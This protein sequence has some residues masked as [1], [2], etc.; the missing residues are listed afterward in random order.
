MSAG[1]IVLIGAN[2]MLGK[3]LARRLG[4]GG[5]AFR[6][7]TRDE[8]DLGRPESIR[9]LVA[10]ADPETVINAAAFTDVVR[11]ELAEI[12]PEVFGVNRDGPGELA[13]ACA[14]R[15]VRLVHVSTDYVFDGLK[16]APYT[17]HD[18]TAP[19]QVYGRSKLEGELAV[20]QAC[21]EALVVRTS[22]LYGPGRSVR[23]TYVDA[24]RAQAQARALI[25]VVEPPIASPTLSLDLAAGILSLVDAGASGVVHVVNRGSCSRLE[26]ARAVVELLGLA[27]RVEVVPRP[28]APGGPARPPFS[29]LSTDRFA[30]LTGGHLRGWREALGTF[31]SPQ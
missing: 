12:R 6:A 7:V 13:R 18:A 10:K 2:G 28:A 1:G 15:S 4:D 17:E 20:L 3:A 16:G 24:I 19:V 8:L 27:H 21:P 31:L 14:A 23:P 22:T 26:L 9:A 5:R 30:S 29:A 25:E 11:A